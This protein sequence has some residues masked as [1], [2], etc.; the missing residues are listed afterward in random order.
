MARILVVADDEASLSFVR[1]S[2]EGLEVGLLHAEN[3]EAL[4]QALR[5]GAFELAITQCNLAFGS[6]LEVLRRVKERFP[7]V[8]V[9]LLISPDLEQVALE[10]MQQEL[11]DYV[12]AEPTGLP[13]LRVLV[14]KALERKHQWDLFEAMPVGLYRSS[15]DGR[16]LEANAALCAML[17]YSREELLGLSAQAL[18]FESEERK[19]LLRDLDPSSLSGTHRLRLRRKD[20]KVIWAEGYARVVRDSQGQVRYLEGSL[21]DIS[22]HA[23]LEERFRALVENTSD[24]IYLVD[25]NGTMLYVSPNV[26]QVLGYDPEGYLRERMSV[27]EF[28]HPE[29]LPYA[30]A[31]LED[32]VH[33]PGQTREYRLRILDAS[34]GVRH[35][36]IWGRNL[37]H[38]PAVRGI[39][40]NVRDMTEE[41]RLRL[42][43]EHERSRF[44]AIVE[45]LS[46]VV[47]QMVPLPGQPG[48]PVYV[49]PQA[50]TV[51]GHPPEA[52]L[53]DPS[54]WWDN[55]HPEDL[56]SLPKDAHAPGE[57]RVLRYRYRHGKSG[58][59]VWIQEHLVADPE[60]EFL[61]G[62]A[63]DATA[64]IEAQRALAE[65]E[66]L[67]RTLS[68][69]AP[70]LIL[71][72]QDDRLVFAN[73][74]AERVTGYSLEELKSR[75]LWDF[76]HPL[77]RESVRT[78]GQARLRGEA[79]ERRYRFRI[80]SKSG[81]TRWLDYSASSL[82]FGGRP[83]VL[84]V[85]FDITEAQE[86]QLDL[87]AVARLAEALRRSD[88]L[89]QML[90]AAL[91]ETLALLNTS[92]GSL[93]LY[94]PES[95]S[96][97]EVASRGWLAPIPTP[98]V[99]QEGS[100][101]G[102]ALLQGVP[103]VSREFATDPRLRPAIRHLVP[104]G[105]G[106]VVLPL[107]AGSWRVGAL[108]LA[109]AH[110]RE[111]T[112]HELKRLELIGEVIGNAV[113]RASLRRKLE[114]RVGQLE[115][116]RAIDQAISASLDLHL[117]LEV[118]CE[119]LMRLPL[120]AASLLLYRKEGHTLELIKAR[121]FRTPPSEMRRLSIPLGQGHT[122][123]AALERQPVAVD[124]LTHD[125]GFAPE[126]MLREGFVA[127]RALPLLSK[128]EL[129]GVLVA[130]TRRPWDLSSEEEE[131]L[132]ALTTQGSIAIENSRLFEGL[133]R[134]KQELELAY[135]LTLLGWAQ[136][137]EL[138]DQETAGHTQ[139]V[140][141]L[142][143]KLARQ[144]G[145][146]EED[147]EHLRRGAILHDV[148][149]LGVPD[150]V[151]LKPGPLN[152]EEWALMRK[153][154]TLAYQWLS[155]V[156]FLRK[157][158]AIPYAHHE[159]W[160]GSGYPRGLKGEAIPLEARIFA[161]ADVYDALT[162]ERPYRGA[163]PR[164][165]ALEYIR[166]Q[167][168]SHFDPEVVAAFLELMRAEEPGER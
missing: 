48:R 51:L 29:D 32:L 164:E 168:G 118:F 77:D 44:K 128:G 130:F 61:T 75:P 112:A 163:W 167:S 25:E 84:G 122:G 110:P 129:L 150:A 80:Q 134:A 13:R 10:A 105:W 165:K 141:E 65:Q 159:R 60:G 37:L 43:L 92:V 46:G 81:E 102:R 136:A 33:H 71:L 82:D 156:P 68:E 1:Q 90:E 3:P 132:E 59:W 151:L 87:E 89:K 157:A 103:Y 100:L 138:R 133:Q 106:G 96:L 91:D 140:T 40:L 131:F 76:V 154:P 124:D 30:K 162:S 143:L 144:M 83:A 21:V 36:R 155:G 149:K 22:E 166:E 125:P 123:R 101:T 113:R 148:G 12:I 47:F 74:E 94:D 153:H 95:H 86:H 19:A 111:L 50:H 115:A 53:E 62:Y 5:A 18:Y 69:T 17:G 137:M 120:D 70:A 114:T 78:R 8:P 79:V 104:P 108:T 161:V 58:E 15:P 26:R 57:V 126:F 119:Q 67:F 31:S 38:D 24:L 85:G 6:G 23:R 98:P 52:L 42:S 54:L 35:A 41:D 16:I 72:W 139:R 142:T 97:E 93:L 160:D 64:E 28:T 7:A 99:A 135:D 152:A 49:S 55:I 146:P 45:T 145:L 88:E 73:L 117:A 116:L 121:G 20:G 127:M 107:R 14:K 39:V 63:Y 9:L 2:L 4:E 158:L 56:A 109:V 11:D 34:G 27:L 66:A 147:L